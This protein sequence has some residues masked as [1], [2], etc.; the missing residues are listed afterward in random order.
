MRARGGRGVLLCVHWMGKSITWRLRD[1]TTEII[2][3]VKMG[4]GR[5]KKSEKKME[6]NPNASMT[7]GNLASYLLMSSLKTHSVSC[8]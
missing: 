2:D 7:W 3:K 1:I 8:T 6:G 5:M 4:E